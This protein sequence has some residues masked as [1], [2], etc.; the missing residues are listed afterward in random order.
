MMYDKQIN[1]TPL[2]IPYL[3]PC[4]ATHV[5]ADYDCGT[6][7]TVVMWDLA[8]GATS[9]TVEAKGDLGYN[10]QCENSDTNCDFN[11]LACGQDYNIT[12]QARNSKCISTVSETIVATTGKKTQQD[13]SSKK[14]GTI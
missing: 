5:T 12:V 1:L 8:N 3:A 4:V 13:Q 2:L 10:A 6:G 14:S 11:S 9:Y 7:I